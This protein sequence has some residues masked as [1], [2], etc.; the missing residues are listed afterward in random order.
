[1]K[2]AYLQVFVSVG[3]RAAAQALALALVEKRLAACAQVLGPLQSTYRW[4][5]KVEVAEE[6]LCL[7]KT[8]AE[9]YEELEATVRALHAYENPEIIAV[10]IVAGSSPY[11]QWLSA[12]VAR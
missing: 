6:W 8:T 5:R 11:L 3:G 12:A 4:E 1:M 7:I 9:V 2:A 10:P